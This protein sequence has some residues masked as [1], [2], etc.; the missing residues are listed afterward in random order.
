MSKKIVLDVDGPL[1]DFHAKARL[2]IME[3]FGY[4][5]PIQHF[6]NWDFTEVLESQVERDHMNGV[7]ARPGFAISM[8]PIPSAVAAVRLMRELGHDILFA[9]SP[10]LTSKTWK[11]EREWWLKQHFDAVD[12]E[13]SHIHKK[14]FLGGDVF[15]DDKPSHVSAWS[16]H[17]PGKHGR[18]WRY[19]YNESSPLPF[20]SSWE[21]V[22]GLI[23]SP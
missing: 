9:T 1:T 19:F 3:E 23:S 7:I 14:Y 20:V 8:I 18:L 4:D 6:R 2:H 5:I 17:N 15:V 12:D 22:M 13:I 21:E 16:D 10:H 11:E